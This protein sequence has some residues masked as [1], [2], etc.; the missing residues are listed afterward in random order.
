MGDTIEPAPL[1]GA[2]PSRFVAATDSGLLLRRNHRLG[3]MLHRREAR[4]LREIAEAWGVP[5]ATAAYAMLAERLAMAERMA[6]GIDHDDA[7][8]IMAAV[9]SRLIPKDTV[10]EALSRAGGVEPAAEG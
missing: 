6:S 8:A 10:E 4:L 7:V 9:V 2:S 1:P 5:V 3:V